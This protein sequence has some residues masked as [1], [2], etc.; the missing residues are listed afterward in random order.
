MRAIDVVRKLAPSA[1]DDYLSAFDAGDTLL[2]EAG[3][4]T[5]LRLAHFLAQVMHESGGLTIR[6]ES[7]KYSASRIV[8]IFGVNVHSAAVTKAEAAKLAGDGPALF[9][10]VYGLGNPRKAKELGNINPG[11]GWKY[12]G[13]GILQ[14]TGRANHREMGERCKL[15]DLFEASPD[16]VTSAQHALKPA[17][18]EWMA[19]NCNELADKNDIRS[20]T[21]KIN[22]G[23]NGYEDRVN[24]FNKIWKLIGSDDASWSVASGDAETEKLQRDLNELGATLKVDGRTGPETKAAVAA[25]QKA[26][27]LK[28]DGLAGEQTK[29]AIAQRLATTKPSLPTASIVPQAPVTEIVGGTAT[30]GLSELTR[31]AGAALAPY[32]DLSEYVRWGMLGL[33]IIGGG[34]VAFGLVRSYVIPAIWKP[35]PVVLS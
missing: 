4:S 25:F 24:W 3:V 22:G 5:P 31:Q 17:L 9:E 13:N 26:N 2:D 30:I 29:A 20:I 15:G 11:D 18:A 34:W 10:R 12:R 21:K 14:T 8:E 19:G 23:Y 6:R 33:T 1:L 28:V 7:G 16:Q 32:Q 27:G 35:K